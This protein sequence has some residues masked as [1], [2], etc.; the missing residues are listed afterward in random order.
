MGVTIIMVV[1]ST[2]QNLNMRKIFLDNR[3][4]TANINSAVQDSL[5]GI[6]VVKSFVN[7]E[8]E[9]K[10]FNKRNKEYLKSEVQSYTA[11]GKYLNSR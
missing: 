4:K 11:M 3:K 8:I 2:Y 7:E 6:R 10:K 9:K 5:S 1:F